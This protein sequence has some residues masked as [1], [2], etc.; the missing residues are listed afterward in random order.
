M[1]VS[2]GLDWERLGEVGRA[3]EKFYEVECTTTNHKVL[4]MAGFNFFLTIS[5][6]SHVF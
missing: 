1:L 4:H 3:F 6:G 2:V 5:Q